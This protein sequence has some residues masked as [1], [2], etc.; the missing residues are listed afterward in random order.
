M[1]FHRVLS[2]QD[3]VRGIPR[4]GATAFPR[5][6]PHGGEW[7]AWKRWHLQYGKWL[8]TGIL[9]ADPSALS[10]EPPTPD[11]PHMVL[12]YPALTFLEPWVSAS[13]QN[14]LHWPFK[15]VAVSL[16]IS[17]WSRKTHC[18]FSQPDVM[19]APFLVLVLQAGVPGLVSRTPY[20]SEETSS[21]IAEISL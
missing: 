8:S 17:P 4:G 14:F 6:L 7:S 12:V 13:K 3:E 10:P 16:A 19:W 20:F 2:P 21:L 9:V 18:C 5:L 11:S 1:L 15:K